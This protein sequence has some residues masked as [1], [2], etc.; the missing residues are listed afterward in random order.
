MQALQLTS[1]RR[2]VFPFLRWCVFG[3][4]E[5]C[6]WKLRKS[7]SGK[8]AERSRVIANGSVKNIFH[9]RLTYGNL[10]RF[11]R[12][13]RFVSLEFVETKGRYLGNGNLTW[14]RNEKTIILNVHRFDPHLLAYLRWIAILLDIVP[15]L[16]FCCIYS[17]IPES[18]I[19]F[20]L[21]QF[22]FNELLYK[23]KY[24]AWESFIRLGNFVISI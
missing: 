21:A 14:K 13:I 3:N 1:A 24:I 7:P 16:Q 22:I 2:V 19:R 17:Y 11:T 10:E 4:N 8:M 9:S 6:A 15:F 12:K 20:R 18:K 23:A 5:R